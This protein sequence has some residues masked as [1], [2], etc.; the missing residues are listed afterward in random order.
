MGIHLSGV[1]EEE[2]PGGEKNVS[3]KQKENQQESCKEELGKEKASGMCTDHQVTGE[4][5]TRE[6]KYRNKSL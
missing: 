6:I 3:I 5:R 4:N 1:G 2:K